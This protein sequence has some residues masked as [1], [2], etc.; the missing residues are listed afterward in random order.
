M[1]IIGNSRLQTGCGGQKEV[2]YRNRLRKTAGQTPEA[3]EREKRLDEN[4]G[5]KRREQAKTRG[6]RQGKETD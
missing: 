4:E 3:G 1:E 2:Q 6:R 5:V